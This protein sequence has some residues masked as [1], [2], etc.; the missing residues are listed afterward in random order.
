MRARVLVP[1]GVGVD[2]YGH[3]RQDSMQITHDAL[4]VR[5]WATQTQREGFNDTVQ[6]ATQIVRMIAPRDA[7][8]DTRC[9][10]ESIRDRADRVVFAGPLRVVGVTRRADHLA[11]DMRVVSGGRA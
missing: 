4:P 2:E 8:I 9:I 7:D 11:V 6:G 3:Q 1:I 10:V 5:A